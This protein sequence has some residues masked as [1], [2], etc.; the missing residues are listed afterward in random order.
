[1]DSVLLISPDFVRRN[2]EVDLNV[3]EKHIVPA[4]VAA[5]NM[6]LEPVIGKCLLDALKNMIQEKTLNDNPSYKNLLEEYIQPFLVYATLEKMTIPLAFKTS[7]FSSATRTDDEKMSASD[8]DTV[9]LMRHYWENERNFYKYELQKYLR[10]SQSLFPEL[11]CCD[12]NLWSSADSGI[13]LG[14]IRGKIVPRDYCKCK[15]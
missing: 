4:I 2:S 5:Q 12:K 11:A 3:A 6:Q 7:N 9:A 8:F 13:Y 14:G 1:M 15:K 10:Q